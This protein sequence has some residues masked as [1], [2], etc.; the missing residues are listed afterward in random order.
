MNLTGELLP[1]VL[2][3]RW[4]D[5]VR[6]FAESEQLGQAGGAVTESMLLDVVE[7]LCARGEVDAAEDLVSRLVSGEASDD[8]QTRVTYL[9]ARVHVLV[10]RGALDAARSAADA[11]LESSRTI[12]PM[13]TNFKL[14]LE[15]Q[16]E[17]AVAGGNADALRPLLEQVDALPPG[18]R[19]AWLRAIRARMA[20]HL[21]EPG[22]LEVAETI[23]R[24]L[25]MRFR[26]AVVLLERFEKT[27]D[28]ASR[29]EARDLFEELGA[30]AWLDR[31][32]APG[33]VTTS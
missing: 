22:E 19:T 8:P 14:A 26:L 3:G 25:D 16:V 27:G 18:H 23:L 24:D 15:M 12:G 13:S 9:V 31:V 20:A 28:E 21:G 10:A 1:M 2:L 32:A 33:L 17:V 29:A 6:R 11:A 4:D 5:A 7:V 30:V